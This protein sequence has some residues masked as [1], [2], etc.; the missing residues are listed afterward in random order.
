MVRICGL[1]WKRASRC[2][3]WHFYDDQIQSDVKM[4]PKLS[5]TTREISYANDFCATQ[6]YDPRQGCVDDDTDNRLTS[7]P[8]RWHHHRGQAAAA[9]AAP[10]VRFGRRARRW[11]SAEKA[12]PPIRVAN[13]KITAQNTYTLYTHAPHMHY[14]VCM[15]CGEIDARM[16]T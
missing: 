3:T 4:K 9:A 6:S 13:I 15:L 5:H 10:C 2:K 7:T 11:A 16:H 14:T 12:P 1:S 8:A